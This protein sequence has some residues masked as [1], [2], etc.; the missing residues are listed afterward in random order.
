VRVGDGDRYGFEHGPNNIALWSRKQGF[1]PH[2]VTWDGTYNLDA[3]QP[4]S[5]E[6]SL[7]VDQHMA[8]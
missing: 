6:K 1:E 2:M 8:P 5:R 7:M 4:V 3:W